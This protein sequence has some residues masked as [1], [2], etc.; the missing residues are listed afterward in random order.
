MGARQLLS[1][2]VPCYNEEAVISETHRRLT[3]TLDGL[4]GLQGLD[5]EVVYVDD[6]SRDRTADLLRALHRGDPRHVRVVCFSRN[7]GHQIAVT[8]G[9]AHASGDAVVLIDADLQDPPEVIADMVARWRDG[10]QVAYGVRTDRP[11]ETAFKR[12]TAKGFYRLLNRLSDTPIPLDTGDFRLMDRAVVDALQSMPERD[13]FV[14]GM[15]S[16]VGFRQT[17]VPYRR[18]PRLAGESKYPLVK[19]LRFAI[20]GI[21]SFSTAPLRLATWLGFSVS[22]LSVLGIGYALAMRVFTSNWVT[23]WTAL[24]ICVLFM[25][26]VQLISLGL[27]GEYLGRVYGEVKRRPLY[28]VQEQHGFGA[29]APGA[30]ARGAVPS[31]VEVATPRFGEGAPYVQRAPRRAP[32]PAALPVGVLGHVSS[33]ADRP[34]LPS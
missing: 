30:P 14:R 6:G 2:V 11:G 25:G 21:A 8:A 3:A 10:Y 28:L 20:D 26:G 34:H 29:D 32:M 16:W 24:M 15:V 5:Y 13:R 7:F 31:D 23:G 19:M 27:I 33:A 22:A 9:V 12:A 4:E 18:A 17:E 1:V